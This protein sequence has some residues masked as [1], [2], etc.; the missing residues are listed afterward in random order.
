[1]KNLLIKTLFISLLLS[2]AIPSDIQA[3]GISEIGVGAVFIAAVGRVIMDVRRKEEIVEDESD[4]AKQRAVLDEK[5]RELT[6]QKTKEKYLKL[7]ELAYES[8]QKARYKS[9]RA[10]EASQEVD[11]VSQ[12]VDVVDKADVEVDEVKILTTDEIVGLV[13]WAEISCIV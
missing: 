4:E 7:G 12:G 13:N 8:E 1:M 6:Y 2:A 3:I 10:D 11:E 5:A 9:C